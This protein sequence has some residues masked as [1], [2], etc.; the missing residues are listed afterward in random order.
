MKS[1]TIPALAAC[2]HAL[3]FLIVF[4]QSAKAQGSEVSVAA[5]SLH[6]DAT[7]LVHWRD[8]NTPTV[9][10]QLSNRYFSERLKLK[11]RVIQFF[12]DPVSAESPQDPPPVPFLTI[13]IPAGQ[14]LGYIVLSSAQDDNQ[15]IRWR[16]NMLNAADWKPSSLKLFN[17][18]SEPV[19]VTAGKKKIP[20]PRGASFDFSAR[21]WNGA[22]P[23]KIFQL[24]PEL[25]T[26]FSSTWRV[27]DGSRELLFIGGSGGKLSL[28]SI[29]ELSVPAAPATP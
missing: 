18:Y 5:L 12:Q 17:A 9:P 24:K 23:V 28:R 19:G 21:E 7:G 25:K 20:L 14:K 4:G 29:M 27:R 10:L 16:G 2:L 8:G 26:I 11:S 1:K 15:E 3:M 6:G 13:K 22:F